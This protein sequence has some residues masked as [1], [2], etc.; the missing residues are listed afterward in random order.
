M[1]QLMEYLPWIIAITAAWLVLS[2]GLKL[3]RTVIRL[4][5]SLIAIG[6]VI[7]ILVSLF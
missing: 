1:D 2:L 4:G 3:A 7:V 5:C 6:V